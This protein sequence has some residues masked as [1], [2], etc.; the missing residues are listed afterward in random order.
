MIALFLVLAAPL[1]RLRRVP[2]LLWYTHWRS[3]WALRLADRLSAA[4]LSVDRSSYPIPA[5][6]KLR[7]IGH[8]IDLEQFVPRTAAADDGAGAAAARAR[9]HRAVEGLRHAA[10]TA[11]NG[12]SSSGS[13]DGWT[14]AGRA[15]RTRSA[16]T[17]RSST[18]GSPAAPSCRGRAEVVEPV[19]REQVARAA[20]CRR[21]ARDRGRQR[22]PDADARQGGVRGIR[23]RRARDRV[24]PGARGVPGRAPASARLPPR[25]CG[26]PRARAARVR[27]GARATFEKRRHASSAAAS[28]AGTPST[29]GPTA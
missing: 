19:A 10:A 14:S 21:R 23:L 4:V 29:P 2:L 1:A 9:P 8:G 13:R 18:P 5:S 11:S 6:K 24:E 27:R 7:P 17:A 12:R 20:R 28:S 25:G 3:H 16:S 26:R 22:P 15:R